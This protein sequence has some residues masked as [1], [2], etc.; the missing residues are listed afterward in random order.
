MKIKL[1]TLLWCQLTFY[2]LAIGYL[3]ASYLS[4]SGGGPAFSTANP[5]TSGIILTIYCT[6]L[7]AG[8]L[9]AHTV[10]RILMG[11]SVIGF[12]YGG[13]IYHIIN[14]SQTGLEGYASFAAW[15]IAIL[16][17]A[18]GVVFNFIA[19]SGKYEK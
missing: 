8:I 7:L 9:Q 17:N 14:Y 3:T 6:F 11:I 1:C 13:V 19:A 2:L 12:G 15:L 16:F 18:Y 4:L 5:I 10:Y